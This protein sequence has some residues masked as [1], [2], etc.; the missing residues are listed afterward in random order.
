MSTLTTG[1]ASHSSPRILASRITSYLR[2]LREVDWRVSGTLLLWFFGLWFLAWLSISLSGMTPDFVGEPT[3]ARF[4]QEREPLWLYVWARWDGQWYLNIAY[5][6][7]G[8]IPYDASFFPM[9]PMLAAGVRT[10]TM[11]PVA[12]AGLIVSYVSLAL[13]LVYFYK[14]ARLDFDHGTDVRAIM[15]LLLYPTAFYLLAMYTESLVLFL[16]CAALYYARVGRWWMVAPIALMAGL[17]KI[18]AVAL[19]A[20]LLFEALFGE[21]NSPQDSAGVNGKQN[22]WRALL[23]PRVLLSRLTPAKLTALLAAPA[24]LLGYM[25]FLGWRYDDPLSF[26][27]ALPL[28]FAR[29]TNSFL[30]Q[31]WRE[32]SSWFAFGEGAP[33]G[34][35]AKLGDFAALALLVV[36]MVYVLRKIRL[37]YGVMALTFLALL[38]QSGDVTSLN[39]YIL[40]IPPVFIGIAAI[41]T[42]RPLLW[43][44]LLVLSALIQAYLAVKFFLWGWVD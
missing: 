30:E 13:G 15:T 24:G 39:R 41:M 37:S 40:T 36:M 32:I 31:S 29:G 3:A 42:R 21:A 33:A 44:V 26:V 19:V 8:A 25:A 18:M 9:Y 34:D 27:H 38:V 23:R 5:S 12:A 14:L 22:R 17:S 43:K 10:L 35:W 16:T 20:A 7:Y 2:L 11:L 1:S 28:R 6:G 4:T